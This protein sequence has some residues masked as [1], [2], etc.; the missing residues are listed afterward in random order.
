ME[1]KNIYTS[2]KALTMDRYIECACNHNY[3]A[4][5]IN[6]EVECP[7]EVLFHAWIDIKSQFQEILNDSQSRH[8][9]QSITEIAAFDLKKVTVLSLISVLSGQYDEEI[10]ELLRN[11]S[12][13]YAFTRDS[14]VED[15]RRVGNELVCEEL[16]IN[17]MRE[18][19]DNMASDGAA[20][21]EK[22]FYAAIQRLQKQFGLCAGRTPM[23]AAKELTVYE[24]GIFCNQYNDY[25]R[26]NTKTTEDVNS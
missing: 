1:N 15:I 11:E 14:Y 8:S 18:K 2:I 5:L 16:A 13:D 21:E 22:T 19:L 17:E 23:F 6:S 26:T 12:Y 24:Y 4:L 20:T 7:H 9:I 10:I 3:K 25:I